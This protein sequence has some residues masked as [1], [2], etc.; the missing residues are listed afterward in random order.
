M[1]RTYSVCLG[2]AYNC[3][4]ALIESDPSVLLD[5]VYGILL[6]ATQIGIEMDTLIWST[7]NDST[8]TATATTTA[9]TT[10]TL[11]HT[12]T[13]TATNTASNTAATTTCQSTF[14]LPASTPTPTPAPATASLPVYWER[15]QRTFFKHVPYDAIIIYITAQLISHMYLHRDTVLNSRTFSFLQNAMNKIRFSLG[16][17]ETTLSTTLSV[18]P[19]VLGRL[20]KV[21]EVLTL[22]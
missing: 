8:T 20:T 19:T 14:S 2:N 17:V 5:I 9:T 12:A 7:P 3:L 10:A 16:S 22:F 18:S 1:L 21:R 6:R 15:K 13:V 4:K 11:S